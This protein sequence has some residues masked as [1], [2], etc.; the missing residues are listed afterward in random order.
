MPAEHIL[1]QSIPNPFNSTTPIQFELPNDATVELVIYDL[2][3][4]P[5]DR[6]IDGKVEAGYTRR[7]G[8]H[9]GNLVE[10]TCIV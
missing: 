2:L 7:V 5:V 6:I 3:G 1:H 4:R 10:F 8:T 9:Q